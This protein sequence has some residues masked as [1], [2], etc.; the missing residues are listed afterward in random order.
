MGSR[1]SQGTWS[2]TQPC[3]PQPPSYLHC[4]EVHVSLP[5]VLAWPHQATSRGYSWSPNVVA[6]LHVALGAAVN[7]AGRGVGRQ[8]LWGA[9]QQPE[10][11]GKGA[12]INLPHD[13][14]HSS[15]KS[16]TWAFLL[17]GGGPPSRCPLPTS[18]QLT[19]KP[20]LIPGTYLGT[21]IPPPWGL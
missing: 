21:E 1:Q 8:P 16:A 7:L 14:L 6:P 20:S 19:E 10:E 5:G 17:R 3:P 9:E 4:S 12:T 2:W 13:P 15:F 11:P 18:L